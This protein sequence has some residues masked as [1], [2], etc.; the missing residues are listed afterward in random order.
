MA[1]FNSI[2]EIYKAIFGSKE[3]KKW[4]RIETRA[5]ENSPL[6]LGA[7]FLTFATSTQ[8]G[9]LIKKGISFTGTGLVAGLTLV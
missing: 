4:A 5:V 6:I 3:D 8:G 7:L 2:T 9:E 1:F